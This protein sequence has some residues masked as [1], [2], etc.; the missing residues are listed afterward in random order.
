L[1][2]AGD[3]GDDRV[4]ALDIDEARQAVAVAE[5]RTGAVPVLVDPSDDG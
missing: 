2:F 3:G 5:V 1:L 4:V